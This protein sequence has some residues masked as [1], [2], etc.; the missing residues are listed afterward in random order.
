MRPIR[1]N[2]M[3]FSEIASKWYNGNDYDD[4][5]DKL[6]SAFWLGE[7][8]TSNKETFDIEMPD[9][10]REG[11]LKAIRRIDVHP[12]IYFHN[13]D[14]FAP[15]ILLPDGSAEVIINDIKLPK[16]INKWQKS[17]VETAYKKLS[18][19]RLIDYDEICHPIFTGTIKVKYKSFREWCE[20]NKWKCTDFW[21]PL[22]KGAGEQI[23]NEKREYALHNEIKD[24]FNL[25]GQPKNR[26]FWSKL[27]KHKFAVDS[28]VSEVIGKNYIDCKIIWFSPY[29]AE[30]KSETKRKTIDNLLKKFRNN[31][32]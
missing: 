28:I 6:L 24:L 10:G 15:V 32:I 17:D 22:N 9:I 5:M 29:D 21:L 1:E 8:D 14:N 27:S 23:K 3:S 16:N 25:W 19:A 20:K 31:P 12:N 18:K 4:I 30:R 13:Q 2:Y 11:V 26:E 7:L